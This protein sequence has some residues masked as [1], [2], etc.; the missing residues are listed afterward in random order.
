MTSLSFFSLDCKE[1]KPVNPKENQ[2]EYHWADA[3]AEAP[4]LWPPDVKSRLI[5]KDPDA[6]RSWG[7]EEEG[8]TE[9][10]MAE[11]HH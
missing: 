6:G 8:T 1:I 9:D 4:I 10:E 7:Q 11:W 3:E 5:G 2:P